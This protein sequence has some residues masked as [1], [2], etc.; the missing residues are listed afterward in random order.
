MHNRG[1]GG[2]SDD[3][4]S[5]ASRRRFI[6]IFLHFL[7]DP[8]LDQDQYDSRERQ[9]HKKPNTEKFNNNK[10]RMRLI[11]R[12]RERVLIKDKENRHYQFLFKKRFQEDSEFDVDLWIEDNEL[13][14][15]S[16]LIKL[17]YEQAKGSFTRN[18]VTFLDSK[19]K[20]QTIYEALQTA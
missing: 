18:K 9:S 14:Q 3:F 1:H 10:T 15:F 7:L 12:R 8:E 17:M 6:F 4:Q 13:K 20:F 16:R 19:T 2:C 5:F 11:E